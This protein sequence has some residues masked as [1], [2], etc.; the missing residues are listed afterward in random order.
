[1]N[2]KNC[3]FQKQSVRVFSMD[4]IRT[5]SILLIIGSHVVGM[6]N[7]FCQLMFGFNVPCM[8]LISGYVANKD[9]CDSFFEYY[10]KRFR[11][12]VLPSWGYFI[13]YFALVFVV[14]KITERGYPYSKKQMLMTFLFLDGIGYTWILAIFV[15]IAAIIPIIKIVYKKFKNGIALWMVVYLM[16]AL[17]MFFTPN[18]TAVEKIFLYISSYL[19]LATV[20]FGFEDIKKSKICV[21]IGFAIMLMLVAYVFATDLFAIWEISINKY[22][23][24]IYYVM[25]GILIFFLLD[26]LNSLIPDPKKYKVMYNAILYTSKCSFDIYL[27]HIFALFVTNSIENVWIRLLIVYALSFILSWLYRIVINI[28]KNKLSLQ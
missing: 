15:M 2:K 1:M 18:E 21:G 7:M 27:W 25:Y 14:V 16:A 4:L 12:I 10:K 9:T 8:V 3:L 23:P 5:I 19:F 6:R 22:P 17:I 20:G 13:L 11:R 26:A 28:V 24:N